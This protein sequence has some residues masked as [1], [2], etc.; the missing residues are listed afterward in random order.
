MLFIF[1]PYLV[2]QREIPHITGGKEMRDLNEGINNDSP[3][4]T[5]RKD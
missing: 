3:P 4:R 2:G 1:S 5:Q